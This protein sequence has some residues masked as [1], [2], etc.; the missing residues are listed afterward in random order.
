MQ[1][2]INGMWN[3]PPGAKISARSGCKEVHF[4]IILS[5]IGACGAPFILRFYLYTT[6]FTV[7][8]TYLA[9]QKQ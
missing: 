6:I 4:I 3:H 2:L 9:S 8:Q 5:T 1:L 7:S